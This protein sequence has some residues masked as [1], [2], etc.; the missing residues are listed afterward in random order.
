[1]IK[2]FV[3]ITIC[4]LAGCHLKTSSTETHWA[5][6]GFWNPERVYQFY[7][8][9]N[10]KLCLY[11][12][13]ILVKSLKNYADYDA[14]TQTMSEKTELTLLK[15]LWR[16]SKPVNPNFVSLTQLKKSSENS[17]SQ[18]VAASGGFLMVG[19]IPI[20]IFSVAGG[21]LTLVVASAGFVVGGSLLATGGTRLEGEQD[22]LAQVNE[23]L[24][25]SS[26]LKRW[27]LLAGNE[28]IKQMDG[29]KRLVGSIRSEDELCPSHLK[30]F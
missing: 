5:K 1:M 9:Q 17:S 12:D 14:S 27:K 8:V 21:P 3:G 11:E 29:L 20:A 13:T 26:E 4:Y 18:S 15:N 2:Y 22:A 10:K 24:A 7:L 25:S 6:R 19:S 28:Q 30:P 23:K 16:N